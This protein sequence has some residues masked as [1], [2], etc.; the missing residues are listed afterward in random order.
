MSNHLEM[1]QYKNHPIPMVG[2][3]WVWVFEEVSYLKDPEGQPPRQSAWQRAWLGHL[4]ESPNLDK[5]CAAGPLDMRSALAHH[6]FASCV[7][8][9]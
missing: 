1:I 2:R 7:L 8:S 6:F 9:G 3:V 5:H 4:G